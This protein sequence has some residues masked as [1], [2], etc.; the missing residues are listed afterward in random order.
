MRGRLGIGT[1]GVLEHGGREHFAILAAEPAKKRPISA[2]VRPVA[3]ACSRARCRADPPT[4]SAPWW[5]T[6]GSLVLLSTVLRTWASRG[7]PTPW[8]APDE[9]IY[10]L[11]GQG[12]YR[13]GSLTILGGPTPYYSAVV[14]AVVGLPLSIGDLALGH[15]L[16]KALQALV[17]SLAAVP[18]FLWGRSFMAPRWALVAAALTL[19]LPGL[20]Y[21]GLVMTEAVFYPV[22]VLAAWATAAALASPTTTRQALLVAALCLA[23]ATRLQ[24]IVLLAVIVTAF[25][26]DARRSR[27]AGRSSAA[28]RWRPVGSAR[29]SSSG[30]SGTSPA[31]AASSGATR[32]RAARTRRALRRGS[33]ATTSATWRC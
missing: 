8:I 12:L 29:S 3:L 1:Q 9:Q 18:V 26:L 10:G 23:V 24:A 22:F 30:S 32:T 7:V 19:A 11:L 2:V 14:P 27:A 20:A 17:M 31:A 33:S 13:D 25:V 6:L 5:V 21:S 15:S 16:L 4:P 28:T